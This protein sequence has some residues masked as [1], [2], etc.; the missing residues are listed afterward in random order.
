MRTKEAHQLEALRS[1]QAFL[2]EQQ[3]RLP[4]IAASGARRQLDE[5]L[6]RLAQHAE[7]QT[8]SAA[9]SR[10]GTKRYHALRRRLMRSHLVPIALIARTTKPPLSELAQ[11]RIPRGKP[12]ARQL[13]AATHAMAEVAEPHA[14]TFIAAGMPTDFIEQMK[15]ASDAM[16]AELEARAQER[17]RHRI[18]TEAL[19]AGIT[20]ARRI[21]KVLDAFVQAECELDA[22]MLAGWESVTHVRR[23]PH[24]PE[25]SPVASLEPLQLVVGDGVEVR[26]EGWSEQG[27]LKNP[28]VA[29]PRRV[30]AMFA[31]RGRT[32]FAMSA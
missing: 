25:E 22:G 12:T 32:R 24:R 19:R 21:V 13:V 5:A 6:A 14:G 9:W 31:S 30:F 26:G 2:D 7:D 23:S 3:D 27:L 4:T 18:A 8:S 1:V 15:S 20:A 17:A 16:M 10:N 11:F 28:A 29:L